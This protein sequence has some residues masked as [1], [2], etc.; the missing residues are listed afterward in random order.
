MKITYDDD[1]T[2]EDPREASRAIREAI[3]R[4]KMIA[5]VDDDDLDN[6]LLTA[7]QCLRRVLAALSK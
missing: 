3:N 1:T 4:I 7:E 5:S 6:D 2:S